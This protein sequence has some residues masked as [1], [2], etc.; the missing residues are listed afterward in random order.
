MLVVLI[1]ERIKPT[2][3]KLAELKKAMEPF[4]ATKEYLDLKATKVG[5][6]IRLLIIL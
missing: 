1:S 2:Q 4:E 5:A 3:D 6:T